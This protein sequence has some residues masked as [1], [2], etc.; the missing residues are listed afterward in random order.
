ICKVFYRVP[1][2]TRKKT[3]TTTPIFFLFLLDESKLLCDRKQTRTQKATC[4]PLIQFSGPTSQPPIKPL[5]T[6]TPTGAIIISPEPSPSPSPLRQEI[7]LRG[8]RPD[9][10]PTTG[11]TPIHPSRSF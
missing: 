10:T 1:K 9:T 8:A 3:L 11:Q 5:T 7:L 4:P 2:P 6:P